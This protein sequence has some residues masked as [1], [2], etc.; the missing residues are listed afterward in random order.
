VARIL[1]LGDETTA[2]ACHLAGLESLAPEAAEAAE[3]LRRALASDV[4]LLLIDASLFALLGPEER[5]DAGVRD[6]PLLG[7]VPDLYGRGAVPDLAAEVRLA[8]G[9]EP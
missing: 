1:Y 5:A 3:A 7:V 6:R 4:D 9:L 8:L 2:A